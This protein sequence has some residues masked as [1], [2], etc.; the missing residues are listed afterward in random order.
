MV[1]YDLALKEMKPCKESR[2]TL[3][4]KQ[5]KRSLSPRLYTE[6]FWHTLLYTFEARKHCGDIKYIRVAETEMDT[7]ES[8]C[9]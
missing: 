6:E 1:V 5:K 2:R 4:T 7:W 3:I 8:A 9:F